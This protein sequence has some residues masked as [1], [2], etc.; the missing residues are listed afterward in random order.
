M[1]RIVRLS[2]SPSTHSRTVT[3]STAAH[4]PLKL[5][6]RAD[7]FGWKTMANELKSSENQ[8]RPCPFCGGEAAYEEVEDRSVSDPGA[9]RFSVGCGNEDCVGYQSMV[10]FPRRI[11]AI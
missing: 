2:W 7:L 10:S 3:T 1:Q 11:D 5:M 8:L 4:S 9:V 6:K